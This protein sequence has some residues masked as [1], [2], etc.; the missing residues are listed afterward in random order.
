MNRGTV[1]SGPVEGDLELSGQP[2]E[3]GMLGRPL[4]NDLAVGAGIDAFVVRD[5]RELVR[6]NVANAAAAGLYGVH[7]DL[8]QVGQNVGHVGEFGPVELD[9][10]ARAEVSITLVVAARD[11][12]E[13]AQLPRRQGSVG[14][15][16][17]QHGR[18][19]LDVEAVAKPQLQELILGQF[20]VEVSLGL[21]PVLFDPFFDEALVEFLIL[22][23]PS[24]G[25]NSGLG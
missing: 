10:L 13:R 9:V 20:A 14:N 17:P 4:P 15:C 25:T 21:L 12:S 19:A 16:H 3:L 11:R 2:V 18:Q 6:G 24:H 5:A 7:L 23:H 22:V 8:R 1:G